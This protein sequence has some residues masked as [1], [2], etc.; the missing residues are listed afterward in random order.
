M[1]HKDHLVAAIGTMSWPRLYRKNG[2]GRGFAC[3]ALSIGTISCPEL[4]VFGSISWPQLRTG[5]SAQ[6]FK[7]LFRVVFALTTASEALL[8]D[9]CEQ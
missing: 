2:L 8:L 9:G 5:E 7:R 6:P 4:P 3:T 1:C